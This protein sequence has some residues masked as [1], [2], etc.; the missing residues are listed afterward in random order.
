MHTK[1][2]IAL[3]TDLN[4]I[5][6]AVYPIYSRWKVIASSF[7]VEA[8][9]VSEPYYNPASI[10]AWIKTIIDWVSGI[11]LSMSD[12][13][14]KGSLQL[15][16]LKNGPSNF[17]SLS[18]V[19]SEYAAT[20]T[21]LVSKLKKLFPAS[22]F[23]KIKAPKLNSNLWGIKDKILNA[24]RRGNFI[25][26]E[27][28]D[29]FSDENAVLSDLKSRAVTWRNTDD[30]NLNLSISRLTTYGAQA[31]PAQVFLTQPCGRDLFIW[32]HGAVDEIQEIASLKLPGVYIMR[33]TDAGNSSNIFIQGDGNNGIDRSNPPTIPLIQM[34]GGVQVRSWNLSLAGNRTFVID[35][36]SND[37]IY[38]DTSAFEHICGF[39]LTIEA[40][41]PN[42]V[43]GSGLKGVVNDYD[44]IINSPVPE[45]FTAQVAPLFLYVKKYCAF[46]Q[47]KTAL[48]S[49]LSG[50]YGSMAGTLDFNTH[51]PGIDSLFNYENWLNWIPLQQKD[52]IKYFLTMLDK[53]NLL[54]I[55]SM[56]D[57]DFMESS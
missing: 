9:V 44:V 19:E 48:E 4:S 6:N 37:Q 14:V 17:T 16:T 20:H 51:F 41:Y 54:A 38:F 26:C 25:Q 8:A 34:R 11:I 13:V 18:T 43:Y 39:N 57:Y 42:E 28:N 15:I 24:A 23:L 50:L 56:C 10:Q 31:V 3:V 7:D 1:A 40:F 52:N 45:I 5:K 21:Q 2:G 30:P 22:G 27:V 33:L 12:T 29:P 32:I 55:V 49:P 53:I 36:Q 47:A 35:G 46:Y